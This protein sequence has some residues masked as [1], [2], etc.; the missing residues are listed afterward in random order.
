MESVSSSE[1]SLNFS[2]TIRHYIPEYGG[3]FSTVYF[4]SLLHSD[5]GIIAQNS[6]ECRSATWDRGG[7]HGNNG[8]LLPPTLLVMHLLQQAGARRV[9]TLEVACTHRGRL[10]TSQNVW[11]CRMSIFSG[12]RP[13]RVTFFNIEVQV[14]T[15]YQDAHTDRQVD[16]QTAF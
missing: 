3:H 16:T 4:I 10:Q 9:V 12:H 8:T 11:Y 14:F 13:V 6:R 15:C 5:R 1:T 2:Q 7:S